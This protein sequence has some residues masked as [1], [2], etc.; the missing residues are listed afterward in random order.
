MHTKLSDLNLRIKGSWVEECIQIVLKELR[1]K[2]INFKPHFWISDEFFSPDGVTGV[3]LPFYLFDSALMEL[4]KE[5]MG[6]VE[7]GTKEGLLKILRHEVG[8]AL[9]NAFLLR[10]LKKRQKYFGISGT[11]YPKSY[12]PKTYS[13]NFVKHLD[14]H[15]AQAHPDEDWA[16]TFAVWLSPK[17]KWKDQYQNQPVLKKLNYLDEVFKQLIGKTAK[18]SHLYEL[19]TLSDLDLTLRKYYKKKKKRFNPNNNFFV[20]C[21]SKNKDLPQASIFMRQ[22][23]KEIC[24]ELKKNCDIQQYHIKRLVNKIISD[25]EENNLRVKGPL[26]LKNSPFLKNLSRRTI[27]YINEG[28]HRIIM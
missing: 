4:E 1:N 9:D 14:D 18:V 21:F 28:N 25:C 22:N 23:R 2:G 20:P 5:I 6:E 16:E 11:R 7:G 13:K 27:K 26:D 10:K 24:T 19:D 15:Y 17:S 8:H 12:L 3:A